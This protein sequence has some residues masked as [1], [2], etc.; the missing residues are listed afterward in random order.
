LVP[1]RY[2]QTRFCLLLAGDVE[3]LSVIFKT[4]DSC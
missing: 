2:V 3:M 4:I 1:L